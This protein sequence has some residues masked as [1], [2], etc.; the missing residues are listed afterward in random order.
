MNTHSIKILENFAKHKVAANILMLIMML[1]GFYALS[2]LNIQFFPDF[3]IEVVTVTV[4][5]EGATSEDIERS[6]I[7]PL[8]QELRGINYLKDLYSTSKEGVGIVFIEF[9]PN[10]DMSNAMDDVKDR[11]ALVR[12][13]PE[14]SEPPEIVREIYYEEVAKL[15]ITSGSDLSSIRSYV[16]KFEQELL[17]AGISKIRIEGLPDEEIAIEIPMRQITELKR[18]LYE[19]GQEINKHSQDIPAGNFNEDIASEQIR[20][21]NQRR[22]NMEFG[23]IALF[24][25]N[26]GRTLRLSDIAEIK[27]RPIDDETLIFYQNKPVVVFTLLRT[28][29]TDSI[30]AANAYKTWLEKTRPNLPK[31]I[32]IVVFDER[33]Q[34][35]KERMILLLKNGF[36]GL[37]LLV[38]ILFIF[39]N[40]HLA[41]WTALGIPV[42]FLA[43]LGI[44]YVLGGSINMISMFAL[45]MALGIIVDDAI[46]VGEESLTKF[47]Q[48]YDVESSVLIGANRMLPPVLAS[49]LTTIS[50]FIPLMMVTGLMGT[51]LIEL[52]I[53]VICVILASL[54]E[55]FFVLPGHLYHSFANINRNKKSNFRL[56]VDAKFD[57]FKN[58]IF[59]PLL[60]IL[61]H[62]PLITLSSTIGILVIAFSLIINGYI[63]FNFF[64]HLNQ[65][66]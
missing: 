14:T 39:L 64:L 52:P 61:I 3:E 32:N 49:S 20:G 12:N 51:F 9:L 24:T 56:N 26:S 55:S 1:S 37:I 21:L 63:K 40:R 44:L 18:S 59:K 19:I 46:V 60:T 2:K 25:D 30:A 11:V 17:A 54:I 8:E 28:K 65:P 42:S 35:I 57:Y 33:W 36:S 23:N 66:Q 5:W 58:K 27:Q 47:E 48:G 22:N 16:Y 38:G 4:N 6:I 53:V 15:L 62:N 50:A 34:L 10:T 7:R 43:T 41:F 13:L 29:N 31:S 45:I